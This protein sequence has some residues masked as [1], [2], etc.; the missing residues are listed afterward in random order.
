MKSVEIMRDERHEQSINLGSSIQFSSVSAMW[1]QF[2]VTVHRIRSSQFIARKWP[3][4][5]G[6]V[7]HTE[8]LLTNGCREFARTIGRPFELTYDAY[9]QRV[10]VIDRPES[11]SRAVD[12]LRSQLNL[13]SSALRK[14]GCNITTHAS[15]SYAEA[16]G[17]VWEGGLKPNYC[18][19][20]RATS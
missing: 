5:V 16:M 15:R 8:W 19:A 11:I 14:L 4:L 3:D 18:C 1:T 17:K 2:S 12:D 6:H 7:S 9:T 20:A 13:V 10:T